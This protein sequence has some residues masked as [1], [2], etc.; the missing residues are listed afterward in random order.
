MLLNSLFTSR[1]RSPTAT[2]H[3]AAVRSVPTGQGPVTETLAMRLSAVNRCVEA[4]SDSMSKLPSFIMDSRTH[5]R[6]GDHYLLPLLN[7][8]P[9]EAMTPSVAKKMVEANRLT[10]GNGYEWILRDPRTFRPV[11]LIPLPHELVTPWR[12]G[13]GHVWYTVIHPLTG[14]PMKLSG[15]DVNHFKAYTHDGLKGISVLSRAAEVILAGRSAQEYSG[16]FYAGDA[17]PSGVLT[18]EGDLQGTVETLGPNGEKVTKLKKDVLREEWERVHAGPKNAHRIAILDYGLKYQPISTSPR[19]AQFVET[20]DMSVQDIARF[21]GVPLYKLQSG[22]QAYSSNEQNAI[23]YVTGTLHPLVTQYEEERTWKML[24]PSESAKGIEIRINMMAEL[25]GDFASRATWYKNMREIGVFSV[26]DI[27]DLEDMESVPGGD[28][29][30]ASWNYG[31]LEQWE[32][33]S[34]KRNGG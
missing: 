33:L 15:E 19:D 12:D 16:A 9:N 8:R 34:V 21:F 11:E 13:A 29:R 27:R 28:S 23:E 4:L 17:N 25:K 14:E 5:K 3:A 10:G 20:L 32:T 26:N 24:R 31:P 7:L 2:A 30:Y 18:V 6:I 1:V 22:K